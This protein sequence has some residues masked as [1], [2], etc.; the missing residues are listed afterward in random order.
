MRV[1]PTICWAACLT[2]GFAALA[3]GQAARRETVLQTGHAA[4]VKA[5]AFHPDGKLAAT[6]G[7]DDSVIL[8]DLATG[9]QL[10]TYRGGPLANGY[11]VKAGLAEMKLPE[12]FPVAAAAAP[13]IANIQFSRDGGRMLVNC[14]PKGLRDLMMACC[15]ATIWD[16]ASGRLL[17]RIE[18]GQEFDTLAF[19]P[20]G[21]L[22]FGGGS[23][24]PAEEV[25][26]MAAVG[27]KV[28]PDVPGVVWDVA[29]GKK[30]A[31]LHSR[32]LDVVTGQFTADSGAVITV[33]VERNATN[34]GSRSQ[35]PASAAADGPPPLPPTFL[36]VWDASS[37]KP[38]RQFA[39]TRG[40]S[41]LA[42]APQ[43]DRVLLWNSVRLDL[44]VEVWD[45]ATAKRLHAVPGKLCDWGR[46]GRRWTVL[47][48]DGKVHTYDAA[49]GKHVG[50]LDQTL[51][52]ATSL[53]VSPDG[54]TL[55]VGITHQPDAP[56]S[57]DAKKPR[58]PGKAV[59]LDLATGAVRATL[60]C[61][62]DPVD[63]LAVSRTG[64]YLMVGDKLWDTEQG[65][66]LAAL[67]DTPAQCFAA[68]FAPD[69]RRLVVSNL[70]P[71]PMFDFASA[72]LGPAKA[73]PHVLARELEL[74]SCRELHRLSTSAEVYDR[75]A[76]AYDATGQRIMTLTENGSI[77]LWNAST[78]A[79]IGESRIQSHRV[80]LAG[81]PSG[82]LAAAIFEFESTVWWDLRSGKEAPAAGRTAVDARRGDSPRSVSSDGKRRLEVNDN[83]TAVAL[84]DSDKPQAQLVL[85]PKLKDGE[86]LSTVGFDPAD[87]RFAFTK[88]N[89]LRSVLLDAATG[90]IV[91]ELET[92]EMDA[93]VLVF[94]PDEKQVV[95]GGDNGRI[96]VWSVA[97]GRVVDRFSCPSP[98][99][100]LCCSADGKRLAVGCADRSA[101]VV[102]LDGKTTTHCRGHDSPVSGV[103]FA[104]DGRLLITV[105]SQ[106]ATARI[107][108]AAS[109]TELA[110]MIS[111]NDR[112]DWLV[113]TPDGRYDG[114]P[115]GRRAVMHRTGNGSDLAA[116]EEAA[117][118]LR[119]AGLLT[120]IWRGQAPK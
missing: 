85:A 92:V 112:A 45:L 63:S 67:C 86:L 54:A 22:V 102:Q 65:T 33:C 114:S 76:L 12:N 31:Q 64:R 83:G 82:K 71:S 55:L 18:L 26:E 17:R 119:R 8:W 24:M 19:S 32:Q 107:W 96:V 13:S 115:A 84:I 79:R 61:R 41:R 49:D 29:S 88:I 56:A 75:V 16:T 97:E 36:V 25:Q 78:G 106:D 14:E 93:P 6:G 120:D 42:A 105:S 108:N 5:V 109:G 69:D 80:R 117:P 101:L 7:D 91:R 21:R 90:R 100:A 37:G 94:S 59:A 4:G 99:T 11:E 103:A 77:A 50:Q 89:A 30:I 10:R 87:E 27:V 98:V 39:V 52:D 70:Q 104:A 23:G 44:P 74:P 40:L 43:G 81:S 9:R 110:R 113:I 116:A 35:A 46:D 48:A 68:A 53:A 28:A 3:G 15:A 1:R 2:L 57:Q 20:D 34:S 38:K 58:L 51:P 111:L 95:A 62:H 47:D 72:L 66:P 118:A 60:A 73:S